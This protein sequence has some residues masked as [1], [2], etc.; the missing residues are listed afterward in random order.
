MFS[1]Y[2]RVCSVPLLFNIHMNNQIILFSAS[3]FVSK[4]DGHNQTL[5]V[6]QNS[7]HIKVLIRV[8][9]KNE[10]AMEDVL[11]EHQ[12][13][14]ST[15]N[16]LNQHELAWDCS[17]C[18]TLVCHCKYQQD[19]QANEFKNVIFIIFPPWRR[20]ECHSVR[21]PYLFCNFLFK[22]KRRIVEKK[23]VLSILV[24]RV[25]YFN[26]VVIRWSC[27]LFTLLL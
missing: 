7:C 24:I 16:K 18:G 2:T 3:D 12:Q 14:A 19:I 1:I 22:F 20:W 17:C 15:I 11:I 21:L 5:L 6:R 8:Q 23:R 9:L 25:V 26:N 27:Y 4:G 10:C 13:L